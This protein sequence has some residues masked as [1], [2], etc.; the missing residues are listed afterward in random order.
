MAL[1]DRA[2]RISTAIGKMEATLQ[3]AQARD[4]QRR[5]KAARKIQRFLRGATVRSSQGDLGLKGR[6]IVDFFRF[7]KTDDEESLASYNFKP[8]L[9]DP[10]AFCIQKAYRNY[11]AHAIRVNWI[12]L[13]LA[14]R[15]RAKYKLKKR[16]QRLEALRKARLAANELYK[17]KNTRFV[18]EVVR[19]WRRRALDVARAKETWKRG[20]AILVIKNGL[21]GW[22][23]ARTYKNDVARH[24]R[25][26]GEPEVQGALVYFLADGDWGR[27]VESLDKLADPSL[28]EYISLKRGDERLLPVAFWTF[29]LEVD[30]EVKRCNAGDR[31]ERSEKS[32]EEQALLLKCFA[33]GLLRDP[34]DAFVDEGTVVDG[35]PV[36]DELWRSPEMSRASVID[37]RTHFNR[38]HG[39]EHERDETLYVSN[40]SA[41]RLVKRAEARRDLNKVK[42]I[43]L[44]LALREG[45]LRFK[46][47]KGKSRGRR[48]LMA[49][50]GEGRAV[51]AVVAAA[52]GLFE[53]GVAQDAS[54]LPE[55]DAKRGYKMR[56]VWDDEICR[57]CHA[58]IPDAARARTCRTCESLTN[59]KADR[60]NETFKAK[61]AARL[62]GAL[63]AI[64]R[65]PGKAPPTACGV[66]LEKP[67]RVSHVRNEKA[68]TFVLWRAAVADARPAIAELAKRKISSV[69]HLFDVAQ[70][71][72]GVHNLVSL[73]H[74]K[75][76][77]RVESMLRH[78]DDML[79][80]R[81]KGDLALERRR[82]L[83]ANG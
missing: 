15:W 66:P 19:E 82:R 43:K 25:S 16:R 81:A 32:S 59:L 79:R 47:K 60:P 9:Y 34:W 41:D 83:C 3:E 37:A 11:R 31:V 46:N 56:W 75:V 50:S 33:R 54:V 36:D 57:R 78:L 77:K 42:D 2:E 76:A 30:D 69:G 64:D 62:E 58:I 5:T 38:T 63:P 12:C 73:A 55:S 6:F 24:L 72:R 80:S 52:G 67:T 74:V 8:E 53:S 1:E 68:S 18:A 13:R 21:K 27:L 35:L 48:A 51:G 65:S 20:M 40:G 70:R 14:A 49:S 45:A 44:T 61:I 23:V 28:E 7:H 10:L 29:L 4:L 26:A 39:L 17:R 22:Y 71:V